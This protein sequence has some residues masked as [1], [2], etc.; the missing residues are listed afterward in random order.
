MQ[1]KRNRRSV[2]DKP[3]RGPVFDS[4]LIQSVR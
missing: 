1:N 4:Q 3:L 2:V